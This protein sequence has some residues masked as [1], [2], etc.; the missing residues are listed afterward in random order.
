MLLVRSERLPVISGTY[1]IAWKAARS[2]NVNS[3]MQLGTYEP[4]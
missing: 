3:R 2:G 4:I 1:R